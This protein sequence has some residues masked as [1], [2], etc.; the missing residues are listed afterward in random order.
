MIII[1]VNHTH[2]HRPY[3]KGKLFLSKFNLS[4]LQLQL[5]NHPISTNLK[6]IEV[7]YVYMIFSLRFLF[8]IVYGQKEIKSVYLGLYPV[9]HLIENR[10]LLS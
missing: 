1:F 10:N 9:F 5:L 8:L 6:K 4:L 2:I 3:C 7:V